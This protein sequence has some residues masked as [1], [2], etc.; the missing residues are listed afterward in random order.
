MKLKNTNKIALLALAFTATLGTSHATTVTTTPFNYNT[1]GVPGTYTDTILANAGG[2]ILTVPSGYTITGA[3][4]SPA[5]NI[6]ASGYTNVTIGGTLNGTGAAGITVGLAVASSTINLNGNILGTVGI[7]FTGSASVDTLNMTGGTI[8]GTGAGTPAV[9]F[10]AGNDILNL[11]GGVITGNV[12]GGLGTDTATLAPINAVDVATING[13]VSA[14]ETIIKNG[15]GTA[16]LGNITLAT[17]ETAITLKLGSL[18]GTGIGDANVT[19]LGG[20]TLSAGAPLTVGTLTIGVDAGVPAK[21]TVAAGG[22][23]LVHM[24]PTALT[25]DRVI[26]AG[27]AT[28]GAAPIYVSPTTLD[29]PLQSSVNVTGLRTGQ[30]AIGTVGGGL[31][32]ET[33]VIDTGLH[34]FP[35]PGAGFTSSTMTLSLTTTANDQFVTVV[36][37]YDDLGP[38]GNALLTP[39]GQQFGAGLNS[40]VA[41]STGDLADFLGYLDYSSPATVAAT[42]NL[43]EPVDFQGSMAYAVVSSREIHRIVEQQNAGD[44]LFPTTN[45]VWA[46]YNYSDYSSISTSNRATVGVGT[47]IDCFHFGA[48]V[49]YAD[50]RGN[51]SS[52][53]IESLSYG[54]Y[55]AMGGATGWQLNGYVGGSHYDVS[56]HLAG[57][58]FEPS[59]DGFQALLS[60]AYMMEQGSLTWG[61]TFGVEYNNANLDGSLTPGG[62]LPGIS[63]SADKLESLRSLLGLRAEFTLASSV[64]PYVSA[65][66]AHEFD[67]KSDGYTANVLGGSFAVNSPLKLTKDAIILRA[68]LVVG[69]GESVFGDVGYVGEIA[70]DSNGNDYNGLNV[71]LHVGF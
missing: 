13:T 17:G 6:A 26:V 67:G 35:T 33:G 50:A 60:G 14:F 28:I 53:D 43:Y 27:N 64:R 68:G 4:S 69:F 34:P 61:P 25:N 23:L 16:N 22:E 51:N 71:G 65:Q 55:A 47:A 59:G 38:V 54:A 30:Y 42:L 41:G 56:N 62:G 66:W 10:G 19:Q 21:L 12:D 58:N 9:N 52:A 37:H 70:T 57:I 29:A 45:H 31:A 44:R 11:S 63:Y 32:L 2:A 49:S 1:V 36:H 7:D 40:T 24:N 8:T 5:L 15:A 18:T 48:L 20:T 3:A 39:F 46:N